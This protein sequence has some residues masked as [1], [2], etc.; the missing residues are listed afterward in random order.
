MRKILVVLVLLTM[1]GSVTVYANTEEVGTISYL[2]LSAAA[3]YAFPDNRMAFFVNIEFYDESSRLSDINLRWEMEGHT[4]GDRLTLHPF[5]VTLITGASQIEREITVTAI[6]SEDMYS[7][8][9]VTVVPSHEAMH[10]YVDGLATPS[11]GDSDNYLGFS[12]VSLSFFNVPDGVYKITLFSPTP[13]LFIEGSAVDFIPSMGAYVTTGEIA[14]EG[15][16]AYLG[17]GYNLEGVTER[18]NNI[19][20]LAIF[21]EDGV[22]FGHGL[23]DIIFVEPWSEMRQMWLGL[24][25]WGGP[26]TS[27]GWLPNWLGVPPSDGAFESVVTALPMMISGPFVDTMVYWEIEGMADGDRF[28]EST[29]FSQRNEDYASIG[30]L[31]IGESPEE[32]EITITITWVDNLE[33]Y[34][35]ER[36]LV[37]PYAVNIIP[38]R[39]YTITAGGEFIQA[40]I[41]VWGVPDGVY[42]ASIQSWDGGFGGLRIF[43]LGEPGLGDLDLRSGE[44]IQVEIIDGMMY[45]NI[46]LYIGNHIEWFTYHFEGEA[47][48]FNITLYDPS[49]LE[50]SSWGGVSAE[51]LLIMQPY[52][53]MLGQ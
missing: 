37:N 29:Y 25:L 40:P 12:P 20:M 53:S 3:P 45:L 1:L 8:A 36:V 7:R 2:N 22:M 23:I 50:F 14:I 34:A 41:R 35:T 52:A 24:P 43:G 33:Y 38:E 9:T 15:Y 21:D 17:V 51:I 27:G 19:A 4:V 18:T 39:A 6:Y 28:D 42:N 48:R 46:G 31:H 32:R 49:F 10:M 44:H 16:W 26:T 11:F 13:A 30:R 47:R 5:G